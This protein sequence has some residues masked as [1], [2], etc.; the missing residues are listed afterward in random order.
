MLPI[1]TPL[2]P[3]IALFML[4]FIAPME[5]MPPNPPVFIGLMG[6]MPMPMPVPAEPMELKPVLA[7]V[8]NAGDWPNEPPNEEDEAFR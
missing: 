1:P 3:P 5:F 7:A 8:P 6:A 2:K 4:G